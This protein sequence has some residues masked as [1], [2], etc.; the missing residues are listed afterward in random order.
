MLIHFLAGVN[1]PYFSAGVQALGLN[2]AYPNELLSVIYHLREHGELL[3]EVKVH[4]LLETFLRH[5]LL[6]MWGNALGVAKGS[7]LLV[8]VQV[9]I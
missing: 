4:E 9:Y 7:S 6:L 3:I 5:R 2:S 1:K 8:H